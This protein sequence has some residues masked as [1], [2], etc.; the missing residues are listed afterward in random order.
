[1]MPCHTTLE[2]WARDGLDRDRGRTGEVLHPVLYVAQWYD[3]WIKAVRGTG[4]TTEGGHLLGVN[5]NRPTHRDIG[6][7]GTIP[8]HVGVYGSAHV[9]LDE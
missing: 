7:G 8:D 5:V 1:M 2:R 4:L 6:G 9:L 3:R